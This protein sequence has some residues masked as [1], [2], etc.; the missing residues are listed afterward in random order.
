[1]ALEDT[2]TMTHQCTELVTKH[3]PLSKVAV[4]IGLLLFGSQVNVTQAQLSPCTPLQQ[5][6]G[7]TSCE[8]PR[9]SS[10]SLFH[11]LKGWFGFGSEEPKRESLRELEP[12]PK[13]SSK[14]DPYE[15]D[16]I[17]KP[18][19]PSIDGVRDYLNRQDP[20]HAIYPI[21]PVTPRQSSPP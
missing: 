2:L 1:M 7:D 21:D 9:E 18:S 10:K 12:L 15:L 14:S 16:P 8:S 20:A 3:L 4:L 17:V 5:E 13:P 19:Q 11:S 6:H